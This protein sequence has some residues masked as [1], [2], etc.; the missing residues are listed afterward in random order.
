LQNQILGLIAAGNAAEL[1]D[2]PGGIFVR[3]ADQVSNEDR[4]LFQTV[5]RVIISDKR[6]SL[7][8]HLSRRGPKNAIPY[9]TSVQSYNKLNTSVKFPVDLVFFNGSGGFSPDGKEYVIIIKDGQRTPAPW[10]NILANPGFGSVISECGQSY[11]WVENAHEL[12]LTPW[13]NDPVSDKSGEAFYIRDEETG[14][15]WSPTPLP[16]T[17]SSPYIVRHGF[18]YSIYEHSEDGIDSEMSVY[19]DIEAPVKFFVLKIKNNSG[20][21]RRMSATGYMEWV[22]GDL[23]HKT[24]MH[25]VSEQDGSG[26]FLAKNAYNPEFANRVAFLDTD[27]SNRNFTGDRSEFIGRNGTLASPDA[28]FRTRLSGKTGAALDPCAACQVTFD[29]TEDQERVVVFRLGAAEAGE[30]PE[31]LERFRGTKAALAGLD[32]VKK[33]WRDIIGAIQVETPDPAINILTNGWLIYQTIACRLW[34]RSGYY[35]SGGAFGFR[36][37]LQDVL[38]VMHAAPSLARKQILLCASRQ[39]KEGDVQHWWHPPTGRGVRTR[40]SDDMLWLP[41]VA[42]GYVA[43]TGDTDI[44]NEDITFLEGRVLNVGEMSYFDL[45]I[46]SD[47][48]AS[49]YEHCKKAIECGLK[50]GVHGLPLIGSGDWNDGMDLVGEDGKGESIWLGFFLYDVL[51]RFFTIATARSDEAFAEKCVSEA[52]KLQA[53]IEKNG[54]DGEWYRRAY[55]DDGTPLGSAQNEECRIDS[56]SQ[57]WAVLSRAANPRRA[58]QGLTEA[59][60]R[61]VNTK[62]MLIQ[63]LDP[64]FDK[65]ALNPGYI[66]GYVPGIRENGGQYTHAAIWMIMAQASLGNAKRAWEL[67]NLV[68]PINHANTPEKA[69]AYKTEPYVAAADVYSILQNSGRGGW[70]WYTGSAGWMYQLIIEWLLGIR[71]EKNKLKFAPCIPAEWPSFKVNY[72]FGES[73]YHITISQIEQNEEATMTIDGIKHADLT[74][75]LADDKSEHSVQISISSKSVASHQLIDTK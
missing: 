46:L 51:M 50:F 36:D 9:F 48:H 64:P 7:E 15:F 33:Y 75:D 74:I 21:P 40:C 38:A 61:L 27:E 58:L 3:A 47:N 5:S 28:M 65:S 20:R 70:T 26:A 44:L 69:A 13:E 4:V 49:L 54:W 30:L 35:Q 52:K 16:A 17:G 11:T 45:P 73:T 67:M 19:V 55:F 62:D 29:L 57:S 34:A 14:L 2:H 32:R 1:A 68:N 53:N 12:R 6:G 37:Q 39:F 22:L 60:K 63:L 24:A 31:I 43:R 71:L 59:D 18:G 25:I 66:K 10:V 23:R 56:I 72:K 8:D 41:F 42:A